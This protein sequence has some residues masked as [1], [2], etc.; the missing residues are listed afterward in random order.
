VS[1]SLVASLVWE[2]GDLPL[3]ESAALWRTDTGHALRGAVVGALDGIGF[4][5]RY[6]VECTKDWLTR[7]AWVEM[8]RPPAV[9]Q[10]KITV[11][12]DSRWLVNGIERPDLE[13]LTDIDIQITPSTNT[14]PIRR[15]S[16]PV[17]EQRDVTAVWVRFPELH[18][19]RLAQRYHRVAETKYEYRSG[20]FR[21][22]LEVD[23]HGLVERYGSYWRRLHR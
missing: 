7:T 2:G 11:D 19:Q 5:A 18:V 20:D 8:T 3:M 1:E 6:R 21:A 12:A 10:A 23:E 16:L 22:E 17:G 15:L 9:L 13:G 14:L 4:S